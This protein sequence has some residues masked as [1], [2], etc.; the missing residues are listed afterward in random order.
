MTGL[1]EKKY[2]LRYMNV[3]PERLKPGE[4]LPDLRGLKS[5][6]STISWAATPNQDASCSKGLLNSSME[7]SLSM[8]D[9]CDSSNSKAGHN[10]DSDS[11][12]CLAAGAKST[13]PFAS[14]APS[15]NLPLKSMQRVMSPLGDPFNDYAETDLD[16][17]TDYSLKYAEHTSDDDKQSSAY[18]TNTEPE[19]D[20]VKTYCTEGTPYQGSLNS[21]RA[22][23]ASD[24]H[25][26]SRSKTYLRKLCESA[27]RV[28][29]DG[30]KIFHANSIADRN[31]KQSR[32]SARVSSTADSLRST[33][34]SGKA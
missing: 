20:T 25:E 14:G 27:H 16:Q 5:P 21:S 6:T 2:T 32:I 4:P 33:T 30:S 12:K 31:F 7:D 9:S 34:A 29:S 11:C 19:L 8:L 24:L 1:T 17:P 15:Y 3:I 18:F 13:S 23:S 22:S 28:P 26:E 10:S